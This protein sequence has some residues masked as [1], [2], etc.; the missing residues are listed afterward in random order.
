MITQIRTPYQ[1][2]PDFR[3]ALEY[4]QEGNWEAGLT[5]L[6]IVH[7]EFPNNQ[8][9]SAL[10]EEILLKRQIDDDEVIDNRNALRKKTL[11]VGLRLAVMAVALFAIF[12]G[13]RTFRGWIFQQW[14]TLQ[15]GITADFRMFELTVKY[16]DAQSYLLANQPEAALEIVNEI[17]SINP[18][19]PD[20]DVLVQEAEDI[21]IYKSRYDE[22]LRLKD[23]GNILA[24]LEEFES[25][26]DERPDYL[27]VSLQIQDIQGDL[28]LVDLLDQ[29]EQAYEEE[30]WE[31][32]SSQYETLRAIA[33]EFQKA[34]VDQRLIRSY[35]NLGGQILESEG[36]SPE[37][38]QQADIYF[39]KV[40]VLNPRD[41]A[42][43]AE[44][45]QIKEQ[46][47]DRL[48]DHYIQ[49]ARNAVIGQEDSLAALDTARKYFKN[50]LLL[51]PEDPNVQLELDLATAY[52]QAQIDFEGGSIHGAIEKLEYIYSNA[53]HFANGTALQ[54]LYECYMN[55]GNGYSATGELELALDDFQSA[56]EIAASMDNPS[57]K[58]YFA[59]VKIAET[60]GVL[61]NYSV[62]V[63]NYKEATAL[64]DLEPILELSD[65]E[66]AYLLRE[67]ERYA[68]IE[69][70]RTSYRLYRRVLPATEFILDKGEIVV[71]KEGD[72]LSRLA[73]AYN[74]TVEEI[75]K[76]NALP[77]AGHLQM[78]QELIIPTLKLLNE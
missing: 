77:S 2:H 47:K 23:E 59:K 8:D 25:I 9:L 56:A 50:A 26:Y 10:R 41:E 44:Q 66:L 58:L 28:Y 17:A 1:K 53:P 37:T 49:T 61:N 15:E 13:V 32:A 64:I 73:K 34:L 29:A 51:R 54:T 55:R 46:F 35:M 6:D 63:N 36:E 4:I 16:R 20:L 18:D 40:L 43:I 27:D 48:F 60:V 3:S 65:N 45:N 75:V 74:T 7:N 12:W 42:L 62:A 67:A 11:K 78:G 69:W 52:L 71:I 68:D 22:A 38:L 33:P 21:L 14:N 30:N 70:Y 24:A 31:L 72:Y 19:Y 39:R 76:A 5:A 57:L